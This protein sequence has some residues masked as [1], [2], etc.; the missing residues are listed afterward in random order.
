MKEFIEEVYG[1]K[2]EGL[3][4]HGNGQTSNIYIK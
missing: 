3:Q 1:I 4:P 2:I